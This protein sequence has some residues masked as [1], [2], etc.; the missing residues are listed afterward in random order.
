MNKDL[1]R[2]VG[3]WTAS[4]VAPNAVVHRLVGLLGSESD[5]AAEAAYMALVKLGPRAAPRLLD[6]VSSGH[7]RVGVLQVIGDLGDPS[8]IPELERYLDSDDREV[9]AAAQESIAALRMQGEA[10]R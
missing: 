8:V 1:I 2:A 9:A 7:Q 4:K 10:E 6:E 3:L 5:D